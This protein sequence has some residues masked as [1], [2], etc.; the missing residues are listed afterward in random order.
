MQEAHGNK[1]HRVPPP[2]PHLTLAF[3]IVS[4]ASGWWFL[5][6]SLSDL[7]AITGLNLKLF[8]WSGIKI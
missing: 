4:V 3:D 7:M 8:C 1:G 6:N 5:P 2:P